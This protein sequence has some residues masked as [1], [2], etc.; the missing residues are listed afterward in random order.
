M[1]VARVSEISATSTTS[2]EDAIKQGLD[3][4]NQTLRNVKSAWIKEQQV[5]LDGGSISE[6]QVNMLV[7]FILDD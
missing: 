4:A 5:R 7:T 6:Y 3:R 1:A 2:F